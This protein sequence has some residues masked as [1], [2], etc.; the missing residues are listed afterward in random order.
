MNVKEIFIGHSTPVSAVRPI[1]NWD[2]VAIAQASQSDPEWGGFASL[3]VLTR[4][5]NLAN[6]RISLKLPNPSKSE[7]ERLILFDGYL[8]HMSGRARPPSYGS[9]LRRKAGIQVQPFLVSSIFGI[10]S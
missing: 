9:L 4:E 1:L 8:S 5:L 7:G 3:H 10:T 6:T 2:N